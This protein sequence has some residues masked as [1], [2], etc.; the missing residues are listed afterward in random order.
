MRSKLFL[1]TTFSSTEDGFSRAK[2]VD[3][4][5]EDGRAEVGNT[6]EKAYF[7][8]TA[9]SRE[10]FIQETQL[11]ILVCA[12]IIAKDLVGRKG[13]LKAFEIPMVSKDV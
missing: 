5:I 12:S 1:R 9:A 13:V 8:Q 10:S 11:L 3:K 6:S 4:S 2:Q 7:V